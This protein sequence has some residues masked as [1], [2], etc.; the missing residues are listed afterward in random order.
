[1][2]LSVSR[3]CAADG[4]RS[5]ALLTACH[6]SI[7]NMVHGSWRLDSSRLSRRLDLELSETAMA[8]LH[9]LSARTGRS[10][11]DVAD[12]LLSQVIADQD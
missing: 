4:S 1:M 3:V 12:D 11:Q 8:H 2:R 6:A 7:I 10:I 5:A 9:A